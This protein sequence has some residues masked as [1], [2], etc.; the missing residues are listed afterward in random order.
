[1]KIIAND[2]FTPLYNFWI[3]CKTN[4]I[5][6]CDNLTKTLKITKNKFNKIRKN[7]LEISGIDQ[8]VNY[9]ILNRCSFSGAN[10][11]GGFSDEASKKDLL[12]LP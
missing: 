5:K 10:L 4:K 11:S 3:S 8:A 7:I 12:N 9:F 6:L 2:K 1:M